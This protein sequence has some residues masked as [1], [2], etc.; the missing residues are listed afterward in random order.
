MEDPTV[1][2]VE[3]LVARA[4]AAEDA[5]MAVT[6]ITNSEGADAG[7]G[8]SELTLVTSAGFAGRRDMELRKRQGRQGGR[9]QRRCQCAGRTP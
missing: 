3:D 4:A 5:A 8:R 1:P 6:G 9:R 2:S 7:Y